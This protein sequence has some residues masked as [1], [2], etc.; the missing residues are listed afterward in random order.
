MPVSMTPPRSV[1]R[2]SGSSVTSSE[3]L[4]GASPASGRG[5][6]RSSR[7]GSRGVGRG[8]RG[9]RGVSARGGLE[10]D[11]FFGLKATSVF[12]PSCLGGLPPAAS[13]R[14][15]PAR[16]GRQAEAASDRLPISLAATRPAD[17]DIP[18][19]EP[20][21]ASAA[22]V[23]SPEAGT[24]PHGHGLQRAS[25]T[26]TAW[27]CDVCGIHAKLGENLWGC[28][29][30]EWDACTRCLEK[31]DFRVHHDSRLKPQL[32]APSSGI[33][34]RVLE[35]D[36]ENQILRQQVESLQRQLARG[37][38]KVRN[39][40]Q[41]PA[42]ASSSDETSAVPPVPVPTPARTPS[43]LPTGRTL[44]SLKT[45]GKLPQSP[46]S[47]PLVAALPEAIP[48]FVCPEASPHV[49]AA[50]ASPELEF[51]E[52]E[53]LPLL[54]MPSPVVS[55][56]ASMAQSDAPPISEPSPSLLP[57]PPPQN[58]SP[59]DPS[60]PQKFKEPQ[61]V[62][63]LTREVQTPEP[64][65]LDQPSQKLDKPEELDQPM[66]RNVELEKSVQPTTQEKPQK[67]GKSRKQVQ[68]E[69]AEVVQSTRE[70]EKPEAE[71]LDQPSQQLD[72]PE[73]PDQSMDRNNEFEKSVQPTT[74]EKPQKGGKSRKQVQ[75][76]KSEVLQ[77]SATSKVQTKRARPAK[78]KC[79]TVEEKPAKPKKTR[80]KRAANEADKK[81]STEALESPPR[82][83]EGPNDGSTQAASVAMS[84]TSRETSID[85]SALM[86]TSASS[87]DA[88][89]ALHGANVSTSSGVAPALVSRPEAASLS[90]S[91]RLG[92]SP[93]DSPMDEATS[94]GLAP[95]LVPRPPVVSHDASLY[96]GRSPFD[97]P[98]AEDEQAAKHAKGSKIAYMGVLPDVVTVAELPLFPDIS[99]NVEVAY[100]SAMKTVSHESCAMQVQ[101]EESWA[102]R[103]GRQKL[104]EDMDRLND[105]QIERV[106]NF[107][108]LDQADDEEVINIDI[109]QLPLDKYEALIRLVEAELAQSDGA[110]GAQGFF[111]QDFQGTQLNEAAVPLAAAPM[112]L[113]AT[114]VTAVA[115]PPLVAMAPAL[116]LAA[117]A[118]SAVVLP[119]VPMPSDSSMDSMLES[120]AEVLSMVDGS[121]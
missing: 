15:A 38:A 64:E 97:S 41:T 91:L 111:D 82:S 75:P 8:R 88:A 69:K 77:K 16:K 71:Q 7:G 19:F 50:E 29:V 61:Q 49:A 90:A 107:L 35:V 20:P 117:M 44:R 25:A 116:P 66:D 36:T 87:A 106:L 60:A 12:A 10:E 1:P 3:A 6:S 26:S 103:K 92:A 30:C 52:Q 51:P 21:T 58:P 70:V 73:E 93:C 79:E 68:P 37:K 32:C 99:N 14:K 120:S 43:R 56:L 57:P 46:S 113:D 62:D 2:T 80:T 4:N 83:Q 39:G 18:A 74:Q 84:A 54:Q 119:S 104:Q 42:K 109:K 101:E 17:V 28:R 45:P 24:C 96:C 40:R 22:G 94:G 112:V 63:Q 81:A 102:T 76:E 31:Q 121:F 27:R 118:D 98:T 114:A 23:L 100:T 47:P 67:G 85:A 110:D 5:R 11:L 108:A 48:E 13:A 34:R 115:A 59:P 33:T 65:Q 72:M 9:R 86:S 95:A 53:A 105:E 89:P 78:A 55:S